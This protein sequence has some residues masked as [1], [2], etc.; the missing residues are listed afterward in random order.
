L[1]GREND[2]HSPL[3]RWSQPL[4]YKTVIS[5]QFEEI[6]KESLSPAPHIQSG[7]LFATARPFG[8][9]R[10]NGFNPLNG[11]ILCVVGWI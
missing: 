11:L 8:K 7:K 6:F 5:R 3:D 1:A 4:Q 9:L 10:A 2:K